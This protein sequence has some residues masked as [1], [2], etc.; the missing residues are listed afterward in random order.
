MLSRR[1]GR[2]YFPIEDKPGGGILV[3]IGGGPCNH[4]WSF[5]SM[6]QTFL[7]RLA[8]TL[9]F[10]ASSGSSTLLMLDNILSAKKKGK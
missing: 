3:L 7:G 2:F 5:P 8:V 6:R 1:S 4:S 10:L 9:I